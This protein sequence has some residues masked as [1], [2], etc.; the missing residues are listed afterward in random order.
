[1]HKFSLPL[2]GGG[3][4]WGWQNLPGRWMQIFATLPQP[5]PIKG[6]GLFR[7]ATA[8]IRLIGRWI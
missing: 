3:S 8:Q 2:D 5:P 4:G 1:M 6:R 7:L